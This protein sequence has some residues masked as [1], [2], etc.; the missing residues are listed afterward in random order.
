MVCDW[1][2]RVQPFA[3]GMV[4]S[5][6]V[7]SP[8]FD[9][10]AIVPLILSMVSFSQCTAQCPSLGVFIGAIKHL[11]NV[12]QMFFGNAQ[13]VVYYFNDGHVAVVFDFDVNE[14]ALGVRIIVFDWI[15][16]KI[17]QYYFQPHGVCKK[18]DRNLWLKFFLWCGHLHPSI[19]NLPW[20]RL[21]FSRNQLEHK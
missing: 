18:T 19:L 7:P 10:T 16:D 13:S 11:E 5:N 3:V 8:T 12:G 21:Q 6:S 14:R 4:I 9:F 2:A 20:S 17:V 1:Q 15:R